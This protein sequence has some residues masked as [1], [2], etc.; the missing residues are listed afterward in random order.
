M[1]IGKNYEYGPNRTGTC[2]DVSDCKQWLLLDR[3]DVRKGEQSKVAVLKTDPELKE[4]E[5]GN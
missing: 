1:E 4:K 2:T 5:N 3:H